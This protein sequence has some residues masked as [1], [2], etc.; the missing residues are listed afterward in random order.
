M[1]VTETT[2]LG[3]ILKRYRPAAAGIARYAQLGQA[4]LDAIE[5]GV[6]K[7]GQKLP[8]EAE[9][10]SVSPYSLGTVQRAY[11]FL[12]ERNAIVRIHGSGTY[13]ADERHSMDA[14]WHCRFVDDKGEAYLPVYAKVISRAFTAE[15]GPWSSHLSQSGENVIRIDRKISI[16][17]E[18]FVYSKFFA[19]ADRFGELLK[20]PLRELETSNFR[21]ILDKEFGAPVSRLSQSL[22][23]MPL[24]SDARSVL[25]IDKSRTGLMLDIVA[26]TSAGEPVYYQQLYIPPNPRKL[27]ITDIVRR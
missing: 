9:L 16:N 20:K 18:F 2:D 10:A 17:D 8:A 14:P 22:S 27:Y 25:G 19:N 7:P 3:K 24:P 1:A 5:D 6:W 23:L 12:V 11:R 21:A 26:S 13:V 15:R 4:L